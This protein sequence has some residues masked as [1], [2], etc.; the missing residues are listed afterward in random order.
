MRHSEDFIELN[1][2]D[3]LFYILYRWKL[4]VLGAVVL[5]VLLGLFKAY[6]EYKSSTSSETVA[7]QQEALKS[8]EEQLAIYSKQIDTI[9]EKI[10][11]QQEYMD[12]SILMNADY[13]D[14]FI[15]KSTYYIDTYYQILPENVYQD[16]DMTKTVAW[17]YRNYL[18]DYSVYMMLSE[19]MGISEKYLLELVD[20]SIAN[21][22]TLSITVVHPEQAAAEEILDYLDQALLQY[23]ETITPI[24]EEHSLTQMLH[25]CGNYISDSW[26]E[27]QA[28][29]TK[30]MLSL[31][32]ELAEQKK[33][34]DQF[35]KDNAPIAEN[36]LA[37]LSKWFVIG[38]LAGGV[39]LVVLFFFVGIFDNRAY[40]PD[41]LASHY[42]I[43]FL[44]GVLPEGQKVD[45]LTG[46]LRRQAGFLTENS[47]ENYDYLAEN[48]RNHCNNAV[49]M[50][51]C[52]DA[53]AE[54]TAALMSALQE[55]LPDFRFCTA[56]S[57]I[58]DARALKHLPGCSSVLLVISGN[59]TRQK[60]IVKSLEQIRSSE[61]ETVGFIYAG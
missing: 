54:T 9:N 58:K 16:H 50:L 40:A 22:N 3:L 36:V 39:L 48:L 46:W 17:H 10:Q 30:Q 32:E 23:R 7:S 20:I 49:D 2:K 57:L 28:E 18:R 42:R 4:I 34:L 53:D 29:E 56:G 38:G 31:Q 14:V 8:Y 6:P 61:K 1:P 15:A 24:V 41:Y 27:Q 11:T 44:G 26:A 25:T 5:A 47:Q 21:D 19:Q 43:A 55:R 35:R 12:T 13:R 52:S 60:Q 51:V 45:P 33:E 59:E 37:T